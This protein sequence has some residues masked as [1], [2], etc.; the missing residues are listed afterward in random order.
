MSNQLIFTASSEK[1]EA[2]TSPNLGT[3]KVSVRFM[4][5][6][7]MLSYKKLKELAPTGFPRFSYFNWAGVDL[8]DGYL[9]IYHE[10]KAS[11]DKLDG[12]NWSEYLVREGVSTTNAE[13]DTVSSLTKFYKVQWEDQDHRAPKMD[14][15]ADE[16]N[17][18][19]VFD[20]GDIVWIAFSEVQWSAAYLKKIMGN[21][22]NVKNR[23]Q[24]LDI[25]E[26]VEVCDSIPYDRDKFSSRAKWLCDHQNNDKSLLFYSYSDFGNS[27]HD[28]NKL[29]E[30]HLNTAIKCTEDIISEFDYQVKA[31]A[32]I[33]ENLE[34]GTDPA[35]PAY[36]CP[37]PE[38]F[39]ALFE[40]A[41]FLYPLLYDENGAFKKFA[42]HVQKGKIEKV[43]GIEQRKAMRDILKAIRADLFRMILSHFYQNTLIDYLDNTE[44][45]KAQGQFLVVNHQQKLGT[46]PVV[47]DPN[48]DLPS[49]IIDPEKDFIT[50]FVKHAFFDKDNLPET[51]D[52]VPKPLH[53][54]EVELWQI[55]LIT[56]RLL[57]EYVDLD[58]VKEELPRKIEINKTVYEK[59]N[60]GFEDF[61][62]ISSKVLFCIDSCLT[63]YIKMVKTFEEH[64]KVH[65]LQLNLFDRS[66]KVKQTAQSMRTNLKN[67]QNMLLSEINELYKN[68]NLASHVKFKNIEEL[69]QSIID[70][71]YNLKLAQDKLNGSALSNNVKPEQLDGLADIVAKENTAKGKNT[72]DG[73]NKKESIILKKLEEKTIKNEATLSKTHI[74]LKEF[75]KKMM[76]KEFQESV[77]WKTVT[78]SLAIVNLTG[79]IYDLAKNGSEMSTFEVGLG[80][81]SIGGG[82]VDL[83]SLV[84]SYTS[85]T[86]IE[87][88][89]LKL[90]KAKNPAMT[91]SMRIG[92][93]GMGFSAALDIATSIHRSM[94]LDHDAAAAYL[95]SA[96]L[97]VGAL[98]SFHM[99]G[100]LAYAGGMAGPIG[101]ALAVLGVAVAFL[102][103]YLT[104]DDIEAFLKQCVFTASSSGFLGLGKTKKINTN[105]AS[106]LVAR[107]L[108]DKRDE[109]AFDDY[110]GV[111]WVEMNLRVFVNML[112]V[113]VSLT[114][115]VEFDLDATGWRHLDDNSC[116]YRGKDTILLHRLK[117]KYQYYGALNLATTFEQEIRIYPYGTEYKKDWFALKARDCK[118]YET[119]KNYREFRYIIDNE[120]DEFYKNKKNQKIDSDP[121]S[122]IIEN[123]ATSNTRPDPVIVFMGYFKYTDNRKYP[124]PRNGKDRYYGMKSRLVKIYSSPF[125]P[126]LIVYD[127][128]GTEDEI[129]SHPMGKY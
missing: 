88:W 81:G 18:Y 118:P 33:M 52:I 104:D 13:G 114:M 25:D 101:V 99:M 72:I 12:K 117:L 123:I 40:T 57:T 69:S 76:R 26:Y 15:G 63:F 48:I 24:K 74:N 111:N 71:L 59:L 35:D 36:Q 23:F 86:R 103:A 90:F 41:Q 29:Y 27:L 4:R 34:K 70:Y 73:I 91:V 28:A 120:L 39:K 128:I 68:S 85:T 11:K 47:F 113:A 78:F 37:N 98:Y 19:I 44:E 58:K 67:A 82:F 42:K 20:H 56:N 83:L 9:Y 106:H 21:T 108:Y 66:N 55:Q 30:F 7:L 121:K 17:S 22:E 112:D 96:A 102:A 53:E 116:M 54:S 127:I 50:Q 95:A 49:K 32:K 64:E 80:I 94:R 38:E 62:F 75:D 110:K 87:T 125:V 51:K 79:A 8:N 129:I 14:V 6:K 105:A 84:T 61:I 43:L 109:L 115:P 2:V 97:G 16:D 31:L 122:I 3:T 45:N 65:N 93:V 46:N 119:E 126:K 100:C 77:Q 89:V 5:F 107:E 124:L 10:K 60:F 92:Y 1:N